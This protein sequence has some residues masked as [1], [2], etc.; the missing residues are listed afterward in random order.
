MAIVGICRRCQQMRSH[1]RTLNPLARGGSVAKFIWSG[2]LS[3][4]AGAR[5]WRM[6]DFRGRHFE[7]EVVL[8]AVRWYCRYPASVIG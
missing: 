8:W 2:E 7:G 5:G 4:R 1:A 3:G 6:S